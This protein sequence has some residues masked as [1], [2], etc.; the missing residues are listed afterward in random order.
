[1]YR[2]SQL[3][4]DRREELV[5]EVVGSFDFCSS[6]PFAFEKCSAL[7]GS[8]GRL[9]GLTALRVGDLLK[10]LNPVVCQRTDEYTF[11]SED[12]K[13][14]LIDQIETPE[15]APGEDKE[16]RSYYDRQKRCEDSGPKAGD[17]RADYNGAEKDEH[18][19]VLAEYG[20]QSPAHP[21]CRDHR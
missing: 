7:S 15:T 18:R 14:N 20:V 9:G 19:R 6:G 8:R 3:V 4:R 13:P 12:G 21:E 11:N 1:M 2:A 5:L 10:I 16:I 17:Q